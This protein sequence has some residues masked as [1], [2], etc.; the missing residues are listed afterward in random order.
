VII[1]QSSLVSVDDSS[2]ICALRLYR[3]II[4]RGH[5]SAIATGHQTREP[6]L[7]GPQ[8][9]LLE[10]RG[11]TNRSIPHQFFMVRGPSLLSACCASVVLPDHSPPFTPF[12]PASP[13]NKFPLTANIFPVVPATNPSTCLAYCSTCLLFNI[14]S[15]L[16]GSVGNLNNRCHSSSGSGGCLDN[17]LAAF[18]AFRFCCHC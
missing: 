12:S 7:S 6:C 8:M 16:L 10:R 4:D 1:C 18:S 17:A 15:N 9:A 3:R 2:S 11:R 13:G 5:K 14:L